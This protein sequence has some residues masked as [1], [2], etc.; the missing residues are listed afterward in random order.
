MCL[1]FPFAINRMILNISI[2]ED[3]LWYIYERQQYE[4]Q[5]ERDIPT[6]GNVSCFLDN[7]TFSVETCTNTLN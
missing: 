5:R 6:V 3:A 7:L 2:F 1:H 4:V